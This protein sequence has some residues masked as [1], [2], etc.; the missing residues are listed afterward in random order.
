MLILYA[1]LLKENLVLFLPRAVHKL[2]ELNGNINE[3][4]VAVLIGAE[5]DVV[6]KSW[7]LELVIRGMSDSFEAIPVRQAND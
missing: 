6:L 5:R 7:A 3:I 1:Q 4:H 2:D